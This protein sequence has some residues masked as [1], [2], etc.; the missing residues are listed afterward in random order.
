[1]TTTQTASNPAQTS[2]D[3]QWL[4]LMRRGQDAF[5]QGKMHD[6]ILAFKAATDTEP[7]QTA[8][9]INLGSALLEHGQAES[10]VRAIRNAISLNPAQM[11]PHMMM[12]DALRQLG[13]PRQAL[14]AYQQAVERKRH[15]AALNKL[16][17]ALRSKGRVREA[18]ALLREAMES[19]P[20]FTLPRVNLATMK[21]ETDALDE[22]QSLLQALS[23]T[24]LQPA[25]QEEVR[26]AG[27]ALTLRRQL[28][29]PIA[30]LLQSADFKAFER[31]L[32]HSPEETFGTD[33]SIWEQLA[34][35]GEHANALQVTPV[36]L[37]HPLP[38]HWPRIEAVYTIPLANDPAHCQELASSLQS[39][40]DHDAN[41]A[42]ARGVSNAVSAA[43]QTL[44]AEPA[45]ADM[46]ARLRYWHGLACEFDPGV[47]PGHFKYTQFWVPNEPTRR[48]G[49]PILCGATFRAFCD[50]ILSQAAPGY[51]RAALVMMAIADIHPFADGNTRVALT[52]M[53][54]ELEAAGLQPAIFPAG[55]G[56][57][58]T[59]KKVMSQ[60]RERNGD[61]TP[62]VDHI[63]CGQQAG[64]E[65]LAAL[66][67]AH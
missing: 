42:K 57:R 7:T 62:L 47:K 10:A 50:D 37:T 12:G 21:L 27:I 26:A 44:P 55:D 19:E 6:A 54:R 36:D 66:P 58:D 60:V 34:R 39:S 59:L 24:A 28:G 32:E 38:E 51:P 2:P 16:A 13:R 20:R 52:W 30:D 25:E 61:L 1:M 35:Y 5:K 64:L 48:R 49:E 23:E 17:C 46:E 53:N 63:V 40:S 33:K 14:E 65:L 31:A 22:A 29:Q 15:P 18:E 4:S 67:A 11:L 9:W 8:G 3:P 45:G 43:R 56:M 41:L